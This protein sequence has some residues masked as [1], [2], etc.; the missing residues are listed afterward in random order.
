[1]TSLTKKETAML[2]AFIQEGVDVCGFPGMA[3]DDLIY[4]NMTFLNANDLKETLGMNKQEIGGVMRAL[5]SKGMISDTCDSTRGLRIND[6]R[7]TAEGIDWAF[8]NNLA[9]I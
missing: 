1:M 7:A 2:Q 6:W 9:E 3:A 4:D 5:D 8:A